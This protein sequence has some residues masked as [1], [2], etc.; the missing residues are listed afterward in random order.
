MHFHFLE[1]FSSHKQEPTRYAQYVS[2]VVLHVKSC[3]ALGG[4]FP[5]GQITSHCMFPSMHSQLYEHPLD[6]SVLLQ[7]FSHSVLAYAQGGA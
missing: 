6:V 3:S 1:F 2:F 4:H 5:S 7:D